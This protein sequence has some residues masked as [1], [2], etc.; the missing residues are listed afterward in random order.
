MLWT[1]LAAVLPACGAY[2]EF[3]R[4]RVI[5]YP[6]YLGSPDPGGQ[7]VR[8]EKGTTFKS[9]MTRVGHTVTALAVSIGPL[10]ARIRSKADLATLV[11]T[12]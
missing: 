12:Q 6:R 2:Q 1:F 5:V 8:E 11:R 4:T 3:D 7:Y 10:F 9:Y